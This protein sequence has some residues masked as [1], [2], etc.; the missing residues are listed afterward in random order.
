MLER[1]IMKM[2]LFAAVLSQSSSVN[3]RLIHHINEYVMIAERATINN[4]SPRD[5]YTGNPMR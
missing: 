5:T 1:A 3:Y 4:K 2:A